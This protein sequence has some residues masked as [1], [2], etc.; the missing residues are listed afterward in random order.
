M[1]IK[2]LHFFPKMKMLLLVFVTNGISLGVYSSEIPHLIF[3]NGDKSEINKLTGYLMLF[4]GAGSTIGG[5]ILSKI[6]DTKN[7]LFTGR[8]GLLL[9]IS[10]AILLTLTLYLEDYY[11]AAITAF[12]WGFYLFFIEGWMYLVCS[13]HFGG[14]A[15]AFSVN[16]LLRSVVYLIFQLAILPSGNKISLLAL[17]ITMLVLTFP[18]LFLLNYIPVDYK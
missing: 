4:L 17:M 5:L 13:R 18:A 1:L 3:S 16:K 7:T 2:V 8:L 11:L 9:G 6:G 15:E 12:E 10:G 14:C